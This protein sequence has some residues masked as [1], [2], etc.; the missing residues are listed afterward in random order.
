MDNPVEPG[1]QKAPAS[2]ENPAPPT[3]IIKN[4]TT[5]PEEKPTNFQPSVVVGTQDSGLNFYHQ[6]FYRPNKT[7]HPC[8]YIEGMPCS[9]QELPLTIGTNL[10]LEELIEKDRELLEGLTIGQPYWIPQTVFV[11]VTCFNEQNLPSCIQPTDPSQEGGHGTFT[12]SALIRA[13]P[14]AN[15]VF[16]VGKSFNPAFEEQGINLDVLTVSTIPLVPIPLRTLP[17]TEKEPPEFILVQGAGNFPI[18]QLVYGQGAYADRETLIVGG[19]YDDLGE[20]AMAT[21]QAHVVSHY[22]LQLAS[23]WSTTEFEIACGTSFSAPTVAGVVANAI[24]EIRVAT[25]YTGGIIDDVVDPIAEITTHEIRDAVKLAA[26][27]DPD[28]LVAPVA[29][30]EYWLPLNPESPWL[31]WGW[32]FIDWRQSGLVGEILRG[33]TSVVKPDDAVTYMNTVEQVRET[34]YG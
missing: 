23:P 31:Q 24:L 7:Q 14:E 11:A 18:T 8:T 16:H 5:T 20:E 32:G 3:P 30:S 6:E 25:G 22:C 10:P 2:P 15:I 4:Q 12:M 1:E 27:Y 13:A 33:E 21:K 9:I 19:G 26:T 34:Y 17:G 29:G 28:A